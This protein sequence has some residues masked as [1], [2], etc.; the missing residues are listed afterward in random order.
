[1]FER[2]A[3]VSK[4]PPECVPQMLAEGPWFGWRVQ[5]QR[6]NQRETNQCEKKGHPKKPPQ[7][8]FLTKKGQQPK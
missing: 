1:M 5:E 7:T 8:V 2:K 6:T 4:F 3:R